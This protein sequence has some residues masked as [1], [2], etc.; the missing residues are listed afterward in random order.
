MSRTRRGSK[1][2]NCDYDYWSK[3]IGNKGGGWGIGRS[4]KKETLARERMQAKQELHSTVK[5]Y[6]D[7]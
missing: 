2:Q 1:P 7:E 3:R 4:T 6:T 5:N